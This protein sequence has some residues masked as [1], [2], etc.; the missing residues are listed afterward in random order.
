MPRARDEHRPQR[1]RRAPP[2][3]A[4]LTT[5][6]NRCDALVDRLAGRAAGQRHERPDRADDRHAPPQ[7]PNHHAP[8]RLG[9]RASELV[10][11][12]P[13][14][15]EPTDGE[16]QADADRRPDERPSDRRPDPPAVAREPHGPGEG[17]QGG[18]GQHPRQRLHVVGDPGQGV[19]GLTVAQGRQRHRDVRRHRRTVGRDGGEHGGDDRADVGE[20]EHDRVVTVDQRR[21]GGLHAGLH[22]PREQVAAGDVDRHLLHERPERDEVGIGVDQ[23]IGD[24]DAHLLGDGVVTPDLVDVVGE[25]G[26]RRTPRD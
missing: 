6:R 21:V 16:Q 3:G 7:R 22:R 15:Q 2:C 13:A 12:H 8:C 14:H 24:G 9:E 11:V 26:H 25:R 20:A 18:E 17:H 10:G 4:A 23:R 19:A 1:D 5:L